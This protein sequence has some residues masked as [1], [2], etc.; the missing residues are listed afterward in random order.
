MTVNDIA[1]QSSVV[2]ETQYDWRDRISGVNAS[3]GSAETLVR[4][5]GITNDHSIV[6][7]ISNISAKYY[8]NHLTCAKLWCATPVSFLDTVYIC[9]KTHRQ[10]VL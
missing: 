8:Q 3:P 5:D 4:R 9:S 10:I 2:F 1:S 7:Y 6:Y